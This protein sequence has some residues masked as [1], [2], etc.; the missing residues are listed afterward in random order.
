M[1]MRTKDLS[2]ILQEYRPSMRVK[3]LDQGVETGMEMPIAMMVVE[4]LK[5]PAEDRVYFHGK[6]GDCVIIRE[7]RELRAAGKVD[8]GVAPFIGEWLEIDVRH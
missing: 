7:R 8:Q 3:V 6:G 5:H 2:A 1:P 4:L